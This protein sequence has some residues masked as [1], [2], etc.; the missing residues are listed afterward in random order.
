MQFMVS[1]KRIELII[2][3]IVSF[4]RF[5]E[6]LR[7]TF[8]IA[9]PLCKVELGDS[10]QNSE[11][12]YKINWRPKLFLIANVQTGNDPKLQCTEIGKMHRLKNVYVFPIGSYINTRKVSLS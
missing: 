9:W 8:K 6:E 12:V 10:E 11:D 2:L 3:R 1:K 4:V 7:I 5:L